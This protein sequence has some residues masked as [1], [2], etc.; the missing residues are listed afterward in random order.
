MNV[1]KRQGTPK[2]QSKINNPVK[3]ETLGSQD[4][5]RRQTKQK[6]HHYAQTSPNK[7]NMTWALLHKTGGKVEP[8]IV[9]IRQS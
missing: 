1:N 9:F 3:M 2:G 8:N 7:V 5:G 4:T 6:T